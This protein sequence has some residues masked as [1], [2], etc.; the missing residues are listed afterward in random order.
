[1]VSR[2][3]CRYSKGPKLGDGGDSGVVWSMEPSQPLLSCLT[4]PEGGGLVLAATPLS[5]HVAGDSCLP[6]QPPN[7][8][9]FGCPK[10]GHLGETEDI[11]P[12]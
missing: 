3:G 12:H 6:S 5:H 8:L 7:H 4:V 2:S 1:M 11:W 10:T 9:G